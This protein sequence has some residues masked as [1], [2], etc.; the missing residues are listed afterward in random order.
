MYVAR[1]GCQHAAPRLGRRF[2]LALAGQLLVLDAWDLDV[3]VNAD[4]ERAADALL[5]TGDGARRAR[6]RPRRVA[7]VAA[8]APM[9]L[10]IEGMI[11]P[12]V[13]WSGHI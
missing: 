8:G 4:Q 3:D 13:S 1:R 9:R 5:V 12:L 2:R 7:V 10:T 11:S 6:T